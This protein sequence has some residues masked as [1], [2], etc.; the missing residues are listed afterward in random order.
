AIRP[1]TAGAGA[2]RHDGDCHDPPTVGPGGPRRVR[3]RPGRCAEQPVRRP[4]EPGTH[5]GGGC[6]NPSWPRC[7]S[8][9]W[10]H[11][12]VGRLWSGWPPRLVVRRC[13]LWTVSWSACCGGFLLLLPGGLEPVGFAAG[14]DDVGVEGEPVDDRRA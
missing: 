10:P 5:G 2:G 3:P 4:V 11:L 1:A 9:K 6:V 7:S 13:L 14:L 8:L 12:A